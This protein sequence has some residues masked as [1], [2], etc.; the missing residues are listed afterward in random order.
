ML[1][2]VPEEAADLDPATDYTVSVVNN[3][4]DQN[5][6]DRGSVL[7][8]P[9]DDTDDYDEEGVGVGGAHDFDG[10]GNDGNNHLHR[11]THHSSNASDAA[12]PTA[13]APTFSESID[14]VPESHRRIIEETMSDDW[15]IESPRDFQVVSI[16]QGA[17]NDDTIM[18]L[19]SKT[20]SGK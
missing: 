4:D 6:G 20:R 19:I 13:T 7:D 1:A 16:N 9:A 12:E 11:S 17:F 18:Y 2:I 5:G 15:D 14:D 3:A 10:G 8:N